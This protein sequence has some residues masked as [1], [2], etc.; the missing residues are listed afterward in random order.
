MQPGNQGNPNA[1][2]QTAPAAAS[3]DRAASTAWVQ[4]L[5]AGRLIPVGFTI[6]ATTGTLTVANAKTLTANSSITLAGTDGKALT[7]TTGLTVSGNDGTLAF[8]GASKTL[9]VN[10]SITL[11]GTDATV[12]TF[13]GASDIVAGLGAIQTFTAAKTFSSGKLLLGGASTGALTL[14][15]AAN[16]GAGTVTLPAGTTDFSAT[17]GANQFV[18]QTSAGGALTVAAILAADLPLATSAAVGA[19]LLPTNYIGGLTL[20]NDGGTPNSVLDIAAGVA[21]DSTNA[22]LIS[23]GAFTKSTAGAWAAGSG[24]N[25]MGNGLTIANSTWYHVILANNNGTPDIYFDTSASGANRPAGISDT[26]V[27]RIGSFRTDGSAHIMAFK[28]IG[29]DFIWNVLVTVEPNINATTPPATATLVTLSYVP[30]GVQVIAR[31]RGAYVPAAA[32]NI[33]FQAPDETSSVAAAVAGNSDFYVTNSG[34]TV[35]GQFNLHVRTNTSAQ[36]RWSASANSGTAYAVAYGWGDYRG[37][38]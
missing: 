18:K 26:K 28:Q 4:A 25:G 3:D 34:A 27:R 6:T 9:T 36:V 16:A 14:S 17:G 23:L 8:G 21:T 7:L 19:V 29:N 22:V 15:A 35:N 12:M 10:N 37:Q 33:L 31:F 30:T 1:V 2:V 38:A 20:S 5:V 32:E 24:S 11:A 13:P